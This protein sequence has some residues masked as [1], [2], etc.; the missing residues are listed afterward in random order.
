MLRLPEGKMSSRT[1]KVV[2][3]EALLQQ[4]EGIVLGKI[5]ERKLSEKERKKISESVAV[6]A[7]RYSILKQSVGSNIIYDANKSISFE[8]DSGPYLQYSY[9]RAFSVLEK[10]KAE[11]IKPSFAKVPEEISQLEKKIINFPE[12]V[13]KAGKNFEP[14]FLAM[15]LAELASEFNNYYSKNKIVD[16]K[17]KNS[18]HR[19]ALTSAFSQVMKNGMWLLGINTLEKM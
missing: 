3:G 18:P 5:K 11:K 6:A 15:Y 14:H 9:T 7:V 16:K 12:V 13:L 2:T 1:G 4:L 10:A 17:D 8:G 19:I